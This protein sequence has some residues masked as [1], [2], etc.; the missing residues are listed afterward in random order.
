MQ[1]PTKVDLT[2]PWFRPST[3]KVSPPRLRVYDIPLPRLRLYYQTA[4]SIVDKCLLLLPDAIRF[5]TEQEMFY[6]KLEQ[7]KSDYRLALFLHQ[8]LISRLEALEKKSIIRYP[9]NGHS[10]FI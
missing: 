1:H 6:I 8:Q 4:T 5:E 7:A 10:D 3:R 2:S 9:I